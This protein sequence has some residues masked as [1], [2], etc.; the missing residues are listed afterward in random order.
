MHAGSP[1]GQ[2]GEMEQLIET[3]YGEDQ[4]L[5]IVNLKVDTKEVD[6]IAFEIARH[7]LVEDVFLVTG[8]TDIVVKARFRN[9][10]HFK[11]FMVEHI[12][13]IPHVKGSSTLMV[14]CVYKDKG[15]L[16]E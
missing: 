15:V 4:V 9:Y 13:R 6:R 1:D 16:R 11:E 12:A 14:V 3:Y 8:E 5:A 7:E 2:S 10:L